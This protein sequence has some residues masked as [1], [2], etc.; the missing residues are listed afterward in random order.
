MNYK[1]IGGSVIGLAIIALIISNY[2]GDYNITEYT[3]YCKDKPSELK[4]CLRF[5]ES[6]LRCYPN[7]EDTKGYKDCAT[8]WLK[9]SDYVTSTGLIVKE[10]NV[11]YEGI[12]VWSNL[13]DSTIKTISNTTSFYFENNI[14]EPLDKID[15]FY[16]KE[17]TILKKIPKMSEYYIF[18]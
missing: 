2:G 14:T 10:K 1:A 15:Y 13:T 8:G 17:K 11:T 5:S 9:V 18:N 12:T 7:L 6:G 3:Y 4:E 16:N